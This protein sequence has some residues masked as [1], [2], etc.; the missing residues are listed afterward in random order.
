MSVELEVLD[1][2]LARN[3]GAPGTLVLTVVVVVV[4][5]AD[6][7]AVRGRDGGG[8]LAAEVE[9]PND[10]VLAEDSALCLPTLLEASDTELALGLSGSVNGEKANGGLGVTGSDVA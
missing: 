5:G 2:V 3:P 9:V 10:V 6:L 1:S 4:A 7:G 8:E